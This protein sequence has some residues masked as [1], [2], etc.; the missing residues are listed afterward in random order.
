M[1]KP[2]HTPHCLEAGVDEAGRGA[3]A[4]PVVAAAVILPPDFICP[5]LN[6][7]KQLSPQERDRLRPII[8]DSAIGW[9]IGVATVEEID[10]VNILLATFL[11]MHRAITALLPTPERLL[12]DGDRFLPYPKIDHTTVIRGD[13]IYMSIAAAS[14][15]A[16]T[17]RDEMMRRLHRDFPLYHWLSNKGYPTADHTDA[18]TAHG[19]SIHHRKTFRSGNSTAGFPQLFGDE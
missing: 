3:L 16:K 14:I 11:A 17:H 7:S 13:S 15:I 5:G 6:D 2:F 19:L 1:L 12:I 18:I 4:G 10:Q 9:S 8:E